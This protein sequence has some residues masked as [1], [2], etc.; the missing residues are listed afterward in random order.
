MYLNPLKFHNVKKLA[1]VYSYYS[2]PI[3]LIIRSNTTH[4]NNIAS[5]SSV[6]SYYLFIYFNGF[7]VLL[8]LS[9]IV[10][11]LQKTFVGWAET[12]KQM[13]QLICALL[14]EEEYFPGQVGRIGLDDWFFWTNGLQ[15]SVIPQLD[16]ERTHHQ[17]IS[18]ISPVFCLFY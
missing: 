18:F 13:H 7:L 17:S 6:L 9:T 4:K 12:Y 1:I 2:N 16:W 5:F 8:Q 11:D 15:I 10:S 3:F 14:L